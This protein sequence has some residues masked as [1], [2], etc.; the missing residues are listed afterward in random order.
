MQFI[1][2]ILFAAAALASMATAKNVVTFVNQDSVP[3][4][5]VFTANAGLKQIA[6]LALDGLTVVDQP[7]PN[8]WTGNWYT[9][10]KG[11]AN[12]P[13]MLGEVNF[14]GW[15]GLTYFDVS[16]IVNPT[17]AEGVKMLYPTQADK[18]KSAAV[19]SGC[20]HSGA[21]YCVNQYNA[22][23]DIATKSTPKTTL[24]CLIGN[25]SDDSQSNTRVHAR[26]FVTSKA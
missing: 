6:P 7:F 24:T 22:P 12:K 1:N 21:A 13:G 10:S 16:G 3:K 20:Q 19:T 5:V 18:T 11:A 8:G 26:H 23:D 15:N 25:L 2:T 9:Y 14:Q 17:D 4:T